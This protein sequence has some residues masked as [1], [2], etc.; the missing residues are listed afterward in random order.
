MSR[1]RRTKCKSGYA[2]STS[3]RTA[4]K[5][6]GSLSYHALGIPP[7]LRTGRGGRCDPAQRLGTRRFIFL[8]SRT[9]H[10]LPP[11]LINRLQCSPGDS[12]EL[13]AHSVVEEVRKIVA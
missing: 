11:R 1:P 8:P 10:G 12:R 5:R 6:A 9:E 2:V 7:R 3:R 4:S 13:V